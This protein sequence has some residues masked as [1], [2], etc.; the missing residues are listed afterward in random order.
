MG[1]MTAKQGKVAAGI[2]VVILSVYFVI[3]DM[4]YIAPSLNAI[5][6]V[7][8]V[9]PGT[10]SYLSTIVA[11][12][13]IVAALICSVI[14][15]RFI[16]RKTLL[17]IAVGGMAVVGVLPAFFT[18]EVVPFW[19]LMVDRAVFGLFLGFLQPIIYAFIAQ[20]FVDAN[21]RA[22]AYGWGNVAFNIGAVFASS[23]GGICVG[24]GWN[25]A[26]WL[27][28]VGLV[29]LVC[30]LL[31]YKEP[32]VGV[33]EKAEDGKKAHITPIA[34][35]YMIIF[36]LAQ[37]LD[38]P[39]FTVFI[40]CLV[41]NGIT[42]AVIG[43]QLL[44]LFTLVGILAAAFFGQMFKLFKLQTLP[45][46]CA[47]CA[48][49]LALMFAGLVV[50]PSL[51]LVIISVCVL[52][53]GHLVITAGVPHYVSISCPAAVASSALA[54][55]AVFMNL[56]TFVSSPYVQFAADVAGKGDYSAVFMVSAVLMA[57]LAVVVFV[58][59]GKTK[60]EVLQ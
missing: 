53:L 20:V 54:F 56:G 25:T 44:S 30:V 34:W 47:T 60:K 18:P 16:R 19:V 48:V 7:Y 5:A 6:E 57:I 39:F 9:D 49:G 10:A 3:P 21:K 29:V 52:G 24:I 31:F 35:F 55:T 38:Y 8:G 12:T 46:A 28:A 45:L 43:G 59:I 13:Q 15:G 23:V 11:L 50:V 27:Y 22:T 17:S 58:V 1:S 36:L 32:D 4:G 42:D 37:V 40:S 14:A 33:D 26:F 2:Y 41:Q 51:P